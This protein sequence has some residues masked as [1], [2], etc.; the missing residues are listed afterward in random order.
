MGGREGRVG[1]ALRIGEIAESYEMRFL[2]PR[3]VESCEI[4]EETKGIDERKAIL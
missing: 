4:W 2:K 1:C 3:L